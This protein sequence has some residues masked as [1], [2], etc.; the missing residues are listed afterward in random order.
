[1]RNFPS[2]PSDESEVFNLVRFVNQINEPEYQ[3][4]YKV[5]TR[6]KIFKNK[7]MLLQQRMDDL[8]EERRKAI[9]ELKK[10]Q[11][12]AFVTHEQ[13]QNNLH[14]INKLLRDTEAQIKEVYGLLKQEMMHL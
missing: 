4:P 2:L 8:V 13:L 11:D 5:P 12:K 6:I 14:H 3:E 7:I 9:K 1:M 10:F